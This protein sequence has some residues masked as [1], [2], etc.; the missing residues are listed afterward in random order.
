MHDVSRTVFSV[1]LALRQNLSLCRSMIKNIYSRV[2]D[3][4]QL[5]NSTVKG[6]FQGTESQAIVQNVCLLRYVRL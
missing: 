5:E 2:F 4:N 6:S 3:I 1:K